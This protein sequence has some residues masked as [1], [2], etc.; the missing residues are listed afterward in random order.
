MHLIYLDESGDPGPRNS[1]TKH[2]I[3]A[4]FAVAAEDWHK[5]H[6]RFALFREWAFLTHG[7]P[8]EREIHASEFLGAAAMHGG[9]SRPIRLL[10]ARRLIAMLTLGQELRFFGWVASKEQGDP[11]ER[12]GLRCLRDLES[13]A[14]AGYFG[15][16]PTLFVIHDCMPRR[17]SAWVQPGGCRV[18]ESPM[19]M[20]SH[21]SVCLQV[22]DLVAYLLKQ[23]RTPNRYIREQGAQNLVKKLNEQ[24]LGWIDV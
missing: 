2:Y 17:P 20:D 14:S 5:V 18:I 19:G 11:L 1:P 12:I 24:S 23:S 10:I 16:T 7:L 6:E 9:L 8:R 4:G 22:A 21:L 15:D 13:W 3:L